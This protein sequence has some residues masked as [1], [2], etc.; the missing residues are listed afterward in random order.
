M[1]EAQARALGY[2]ITQE[3]SGRWYIQLTRTHVVN[4]QGDGYATQD[5]ALDGLA[6]ELDPLLEETS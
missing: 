3:A 2:V 4:K 5:D 6:D 1:T